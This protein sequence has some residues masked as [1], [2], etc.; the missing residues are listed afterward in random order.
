MDYVRNEV[1]KRAKDYV[2]KCLAEKELLVAKFILENP[3][4]PIDNIEIVHSVSGDGLSISVQ[5]RG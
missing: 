3:S 4:I 5:C 2:E 1:N